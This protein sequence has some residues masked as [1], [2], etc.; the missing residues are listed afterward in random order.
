VNRTYKHTHIY[1]N[2]PKIERIVSEKK[3]IKKFHLTFLRL[4]FIILLSDSADTIIL[5]HIN[6]DLHSFTYM[7]E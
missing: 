3:C 7:N 4:F 5:S 1:I 2:V 6:V